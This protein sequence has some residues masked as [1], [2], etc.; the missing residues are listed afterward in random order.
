VLRGRLVTDSFLTDLDALQRCCFILHENAIAFPKKKKASL[1]PASLKTA[2]NM[3]GGRVSTH[4]TKHSVQ[5]TD[6]F[7]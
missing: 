2:P 6:L 7:P 1:Q 5:E 4:N 3:E